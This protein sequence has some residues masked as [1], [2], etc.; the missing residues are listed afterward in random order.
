VRRLYA[1]LFLVTLATVMFQVLLTRVFS[2]TMWYHFAFMAIS[3]AMFGLTVGA[4]IVFLRPRWW[5]Q[6]RLAAAMALCALGFALTMAAV[7]LLQTVFLPSGWS[8]YLNFAAAAVPF[9]LSGIFVC[10]ALTRFPARIG[11][12]Y[13]FDLAGAALGCLAVIAALAWLDGIGALLGCASIA[14]LA[15][16]LLA[17]GRA[18]AAAVAATAVLAATTLWAGVHLARHDLAAFPIQYIKWQKQQEIDYERWNSFSRIAVM[19]PSAGDVPAW[20]LSIAYTDRVKVPTR[21]LQIDAGAGTVLLGFDGDLAGFEFLRWDLTN[22]AHHLRRDARVC[23]VGSGGGRDILAAKVFGQ[24]QAVAVEINGDILRVANHR[25]GAYTG[26]LDR[27]PS[28]RLVNDEARSYLARTRERF[29]IVQLTFIDT[30]AA[31]AG[32]AYALMENPLYTVEGWG[33]FLDRLED[34]GLLA[35]A[36]GANFEIARLV[37]L[38]REAL[39]AAGA[40]QPER[41]MVLVSNRH[42]RADA[43]GPMSLLLVRKS[44]FPEHEL[45]EVRE[46]ARRMRFEID[47]EP[48]VAQSR[49]LDALASGRALQELDWSAT[50]YDAP[51]DDQPFFF[52]MLKLG[53]WLFVRESR[54]LGQHAAIVLMDLLTIVTA[55]TLVCIALPLALGRVVPRRSDAALLAYFAAIGA[56][57]MLIEIS[58]LQRLIIFLGHPVYSLSVILFVLLAAGGLGSYLSARVREPRRLLVALVVVLAA[59]GIA[60]GLLV[61]A[62]QAAETPTRIAAAAGLL[63]PMGVFMGMAFPLGMRLACASRPQLTPMLWGVNGAL[64]VLASVLA[65]VIAIA[66]GISA[67]YWTGVASYAV[68]AAA[69]AVASR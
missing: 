29:D 59:A 69:L 51:T 18:R 56:G 44:P 2:L 34:D 46:H 48:G 27:D 49:I 40:A 20:S 54:A 39:R 63:A 23:I 19:K 7:V 11:E 21:L 47:L 13:A 57:F 36:R 43:Y 50:N 5:P 68:A 8:L 1:A 22:F 60:S 16:S 62:L 15:G 17:R 35:V 32:G 24:K 58:M 64:S 26:H 9:V 65:I 12:L 41:H 38:G 3:I 28:V 66:F 14:A 53:T 52:N 31:S 55:M 4:L 67:S 10:L 37:A 61:T 30:W 45:A 42:V 33:I 25:F 6:E